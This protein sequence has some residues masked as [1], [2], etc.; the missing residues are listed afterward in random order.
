MHR[1]LKPDNVMLSNR[2]ALVMDFGVAKAVS[3]A[4]GRQELT[5]AGVALG[6][7]AYMSPEQATAD[8]QTD[9][10]ADI[11]AVGA[12]AYELLTGVPPFSGPNA[13]AILS[14]HVTQEPEPVT[15]RRPTVPPVLADL[16]MRCLAK[17][18]ADRWQ[19]AEEM[20]AVLE[21]LTTTSG[22]ITPTQTLP[23]AAAR[24][25]SRSVLR[26]AAA[27]V[28]AG[29]VV[30]A[31]FLLWVPR[32]EPD[33]PTPVARQ[34]TFRGDVQSVALAKDGALSRM[35]PREVVP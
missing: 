34:V 25:R 15:T 22:G 26:I 30:A 28:G 32:G 12:M 35:W 3:E 21:G 4:T 6:T 19:S 14:A 1:D 31:G 9:H 27:I 20:L 29:A 16:V 8:P 23:V 18:P 10:R 5:T 7:P 33:V 11:Y 24:G 17:K 2:H 13:R